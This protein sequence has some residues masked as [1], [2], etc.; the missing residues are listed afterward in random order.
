MNTS[1]TTVAQYQQ[2]C[3]DTRAALAECRRT[4]NA[5]DGHIRAAAA[6]G[7]PRTDIAELVG[8]SRAQV[9]TILRAGR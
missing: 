6:L 1:R 5:R 7:I 4:A 9:Q 8:L 3:E 2:L